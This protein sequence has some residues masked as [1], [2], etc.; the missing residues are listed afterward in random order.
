MRTETPQ[1]VRLADYTPY[2]FAVE[3]VDLDFNLDP[4]ATRVRSVMALRRTGAA[5][6]PL[7]LNGENLELVSIAVD[8]VPLGNNSY[9]VDGKTLTVPGLPD[10]CELAIETRFAPRDN[11][12]L[13]GLYMSGGRYCTQCE[14]EGFRRITYYPDRPD[15]MSRFTTRIEAPRDDFPTLLSNGNLLE[16]G[17]LP[18]GRHFAR[19]QDPFKKPAYLFALVAG[20]FDMIEDAFTTMSGRTIPLRIYVDPGDAPRAHYA[21]DALKRAMRWD[22]EAFGR[23]YD[24]DLFMIV[25]VR[26]FNFGAMENKGLNIFNSSVLLADAQTATDSDFEHIESVVAHEYFHNW[27]GNRITCRDWFQLCL[28]EGLTVFRDQEFSASQRGAAICR[29]KDV[30]ALRAR[31]FPED[32]GPLAHPVRPDEYLKIDNFYTATIYE[33]GAELV[34]MLRTLIGDEAFARGMDHYFAT[35]DGTAATVEQ[36]LQAFEQANGLDLSAFRKW[37]SQAGT[38]V[39]SASESWDEA[40]GTL[41]LTLRQ[42]TPPTP[43]QDS[44]QPLP[45]PVRAGLVGETGPLPMTLQ[46]EAQ[47]G[48]LERLLVLEGAEKSWTFHGLSERP[49][50]SLLRGFSA[51]V[52][53]Q[54]ARSPAERARLMR[55]DP[56]PFR[57]WEEAQAYGLEVLLAMASGGKQAPDAAYLEAL[58]ALAADES[59]EPAFAALAIMPPTELDVFSHMRP[60]DPGRI[61]SAR[62]TLLRQL[63]QDQRQALEHALARSQPRGAFTPDAASAGRRALHGAALNILARL[64]PQEGGALAQQAFADASN[65]TASLAA[66]TALDHSGSAAFDEALAAF[67]ARWKANPLVLDKWFA[68]QARS[69]RSDVAQRVRALLQHPLYSHDNPNRARS[70]LGVF[71]QANLAAFHAADGSGYALLAD[72]VRAIDPVNPA[73]AARL[74]GAFESWPQLEPGRAGLARDT[75]ESLLQTPDLSANSYEIITRQLAAKERAA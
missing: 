19:W 45:I 44:K 1:P 30:K 56:D 32:A 48:P 8:G 7:V 68:V 58:G 70:V 2:P 5:D 43:G 17:D 51:P 36:F 6:A 27:T 11:R 38:P 42:H 46:G 53:L 55:L 74:L 13:S 61:R 21:M 23:E 29:I 35:L 73:L 16:T 15:V 25:A 66:L 60:A 26:D 52:N 49:L 4:D 22:E 64:G 41:T 33:K 59:I 62:E 28:K 31:Q 69:V 10:A 39:L 14:A 57:R 67:F 63:A 40:A 12:A 54:Q 9:S 47:D 18:G 50:V 65:M 24:L 3:T 34:R 20:A 71:S 72:A 37:Y 75:L